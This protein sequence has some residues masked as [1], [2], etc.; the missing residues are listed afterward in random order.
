MTKYIILIA[1]LCFESYLS[2]QIKHDVK[3][4]QQIYNVKKSQTKYN[5][6]ES[7]Q[8]YDVKDSVKIFFRQGK[9]NLDPT[10]S[11]NQWALN[12]IADTL[13]SNYA[14][15]AYQLRKILVVGAASPEG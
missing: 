12:R 6:K 3:K 7:Q 15:S 10:L 2:A 5:V 13:R 11:D 14:D 4:S 8:I 9:I 1:F